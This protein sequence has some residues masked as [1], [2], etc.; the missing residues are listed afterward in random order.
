MAKCYYTVIKE[1][2]GVAKNAVKHGLHLVEIF[3]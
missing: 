3:A 2:T 1:L